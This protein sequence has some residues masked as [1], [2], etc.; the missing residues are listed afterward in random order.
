M[1]STTCAHPG[2]FGCRD[3]SS[4][5]STPTQTPPPGDTTSCESPGFFWGCWDPKT[6]SDHPITTPP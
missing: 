2:W 5:T 4:P 6:T 1:T 3:P